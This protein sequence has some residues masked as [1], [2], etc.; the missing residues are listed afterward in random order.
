MNPSTVIGNNC[1]LSQF[2]TI[3]SNYDK[4]LLSVTIPISDLMFAL[5]KMLKS[6]AMLPL[7]PEVL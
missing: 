1:N 2:I 7:V 6:A 5:W 3:G 4:G